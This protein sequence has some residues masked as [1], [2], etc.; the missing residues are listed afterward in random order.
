MKRGIHIVTPNKMFGS[1][2]MERYA[3]LR[4]LA[5][6]DCTH[7]FYEVRFACGVLLAPSLN[8]NC[9]VLCDA[10]FPQNAAAQ[11]QTG[12]SKSSALH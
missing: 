10:C 3:A 11:P 12:G 2:P 6:A 9:I 1:G 4:R 8:C 5:R 7:W